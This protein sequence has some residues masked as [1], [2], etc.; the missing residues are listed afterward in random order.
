[1]IP[2]DD[3]LYSLLG[4][5][6]CSILGAIESTGLYPRK[7]KHD[8]VFSS[9]Q[10]SEQSAMLSWRGK[11]SDND[12]DI[13]QFDKNFAKLIKSGFGFFDRNT[14][15]LKALVSFVRMD[16]F[17]EFGA[18]EGIEIKGKKYRWNHL[19]VKSKPKTI[20]PSNHLSMHHFLYCCDKTSATNIPTKDFINRVES[21]NLSESK[22]GYRG[23]SFGDKIFFVFEIKT[24]PTNPQ[25]ETLL[26]KL[27][28]ECLGP[29][30]I[31]FDPEA[32]RALIERGRL[33]PEL[34]RHIEAWE[35]MKR[36][37]S[38]WVYGEDKAE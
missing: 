5:Q 37:G 9:F 19:P 38:K 26:A 21:V 25:P 8:D 35:E 18:T 34:K 12:S 10:I 14:V 7:D 15:E 36:T 33:H 31:P 32:R 11:I 30:P 28:N 13:I 17:G 20:F 1:L 23:S 29:N 2:A 4:T 22:K 6:E 3:W 24:T 27:W 16:V